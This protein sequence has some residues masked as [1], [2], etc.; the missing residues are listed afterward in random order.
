MSQCTCKRVIVKRTELNVVQGVGWCLIIKFNNT[1][2]KERPIQEEMLLTVEGL[3]LTEK[4]LLDLFMFVIQMI[5]PSLAGVLFVWLFFEF[6]GAASQ[7]YCTADVNPCIME[8]SSSLSS[9]GGPRAANDLSSC[10]VTN[11]TTHVNIHLFNDSNYSHLI[12]C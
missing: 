3:P 8:H 6:W 10:Q 11:I 5:R 12:K 4:I 2:K 7:R 1:P 9:F